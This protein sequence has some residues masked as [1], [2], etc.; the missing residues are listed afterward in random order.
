MR[1]NTRR[2]AI[3]APVTSASLG[4][5][6]GKAR[7]V[8]LGESAHGIEATLAARNEVFRYLARDQEAA[9]MRRR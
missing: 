9:R 4:R 1:V 8:A 5:L 7:V 2:G 6:A 3:A